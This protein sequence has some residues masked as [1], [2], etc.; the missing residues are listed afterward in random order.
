MYNI[1]TLFLLNQVQNIIYLHI[2][3]DK[4]DVL[5]HYVEVRVTQ[6]RTVRQSAALDQ[7]TA[8]GL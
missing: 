5:R 3:N 8:V 4:P 6:W 7:L 2:L 1:L